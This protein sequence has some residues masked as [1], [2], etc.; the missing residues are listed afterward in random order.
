MTESRQTAYKSIFTVPKMDCPSEE[1]MIRMALEGVDGLRSLAFDL[2]GRTLVVVHHGSAQAL[3]RRLEPLGL[4]AALTQSEPLQHGDDDSEIEPPSSSAESALLKQMLFINATM[5]VVELIV[6]VIAESTGLIADSL[7]MFADAAV[8]GLSLFAVGH[9]A[10]TKVRA[11]HVAGWVQLA[12]ALGAIAEVARRFIYGSEPASL[13]M[14][15]MG[16]GALVANAYCLWAMAKQRNNGAHMK[17]S[18]IFLANDVVANGGVILAGVLV[19]LTQSR[20]P[21]LV[22]GTVVAVV[23]LNG[24]RRI[25]ALEA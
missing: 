6:G 17:A 19:A 1:R 16:A 3:T 23:V 25:L 22:I 14:I 4:G 12:L 24:A 7:D 2:Q 10:A 5:F 11:A 13:L 21:D 9:T 15:V 8:L 20:Y 18:Y